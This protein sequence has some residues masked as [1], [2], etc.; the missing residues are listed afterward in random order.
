[1]PLQTDIISMRSRYIQTV[2]IRSS[3]TVVLIVVNSTDNSSSGST[4]VPVPARPTVCDHVY[5]C[6]HVV[7]TQLPWRATTAAAV[8]TIPTP[9]RPAAHV[10]FIE[11][12]VYC[13][14]LLFNFN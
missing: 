7:K 4:A 6:A 8:H 3:K 12:S 5:W 13:T 11:Y 9:R 2:T 1:M 14:M 10:L